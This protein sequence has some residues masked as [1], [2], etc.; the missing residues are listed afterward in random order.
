MKKIT[1]IILFTICALNSFAQDHNF[2]QFYA[3]PIYLNPAL[4]GAMNGCFRLAANYRNQWP[5]IPGM[6]QYY[7]FSADLKSK[8]IS[9]GIGLLF[10]RSEEGQGFFI[11]NNFAAN[12]SFHRQLTDGIISHSGISA[13]FFSRNVDFNKLI[14]ADQIDVEQ[15]IN[16]NWPTLAIPPVY[17]SITKAD[18][19]FGQVFLLPKF[20]SMIGFSWKH[21][22]EPD[23]SLTGITTILPAK[24]TLHIS[25]LIT[26]GRPR[27]YTYLAPTVVFYQQGNFNAFQV[28]TWFKSDYFNVGLWYRNNK[29]F[30]GNDALIMTFSFDTFKG[31]DKK[32]EKLQAGF[33]YDASI[34]QLAQRNT[35]GSLEGS[36]IFETKPCF[37]NQVYE[38]RNSAKFKSYQKSG[39]FRGF[40]NFLNKIS[41][42]SRFKDRK[43][44]CTDF[45]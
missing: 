8:A 32:G 9:G 19:G 43:R 22:F 21:M 4:T 28:G 13:G 17:N 14:F 36:V 12:Y 11:K 2:S 31:K 20:S 41:G 25:N 18:F 35:V 34:N 24:Y 16:Q 15:G 44:T 7:N 40:N 27:H 6:M 38:T 30:R 3:S 29:T 33:S 39:A 1:Y 45:F 23:E 37:D 26:L 42:G 5:G 10:S